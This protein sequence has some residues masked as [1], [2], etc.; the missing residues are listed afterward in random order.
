MKVAFL[1]R[2]GTI[3][4]DYSDE[5]WRTV[6][7]PQFLD[8]VF[9]A[10]Q[11]FQAFGF[12][13]IVVTNQYIIE[14]GFITLKQYEDF[15]ARMLSQLNNE[16]V[17]I[18]DT[19]YCPHA[20]YAECMCCKPKP[21]LIQ[22]ALNK[23]PSIDFSQSFLAGDRI[24]DIELANHFNIRSFSIGFDSGIDGVSRVNNLSEITKVIT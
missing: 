18:L 19:F 23:Y 8:G 3:V 7:Q 22:Q 16:G 11:S 5:Q 4:S 12:E 24:S 20:R 9:E 1:D 17:S 14:E 6:S 21:G 2:D 10:L 15:Q 13:I